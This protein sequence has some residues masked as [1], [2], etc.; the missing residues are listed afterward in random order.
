MRQLIGPKGGLPTLKGDLLKL[1]ALLNM[2]LRDSMKVEEI[3]ELIKPMMATLKGTASS[4]SSDAVDPKAKAAS[5]KG[6][7][8]K[9]Q[10][11][12]P[13][14]P[15]AEPSIAMATTSDEVRQM[16]AQQELRFQSMMN[17]MMQH[18]MS[19]Q[20]VP[21]SGG[22]RDFTDEEMDEINAAYAEQMEEEAFWAVHGEEAD[23]MT[24]QERA[25]ALDHLN[26]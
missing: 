17:Q 24:A 20:Q 1:G 22:A 7:R 25:D 18:M 10:T 21:T 14:R 19:L 23:W 5:K 26:S 6:A 16:L 3:K 8:P 13:S 11:S 9:S 12:P 4:S 15:P 2:D